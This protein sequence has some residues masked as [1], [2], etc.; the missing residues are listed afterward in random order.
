MS[1]QSNIPQWPKGLTDETPLPFIVWQVMDVVD[2]QRSLQAISQTLQISMPEIQKVLQEVEQWVSRASQRGQ[3]LTSELN[4]I[5][6]SSLM[7]VVGPVA[8]IMVDDALEDL[9]AT[10]TLSTL[11]DNLATQLSAERVQQFARQLHDRGLT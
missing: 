7:A 4:K 8:D 10:A 9:G 5:I 1:M 11:L 6:K 3:R 2:G